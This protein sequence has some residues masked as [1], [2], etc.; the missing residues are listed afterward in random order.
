MPLAQLKPTFDQPDQAPVARVVAKPDGVA[1]RSPAVALQQ[2]LEQGV[3]PKASPDR[4]APRHA[5]A[6]IVASSFA[7]W[8]AILEA[9]AQAVHAIA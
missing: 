2:R 9:G 1:G 7:L 5:M 8:V 6:V 3:A 4:W